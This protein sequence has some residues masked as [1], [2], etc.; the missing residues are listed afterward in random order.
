MNPSILFFAGSSR[1]ES[2]HKKL[3]RQAAT[4]ARQLGYESRFLDLKD[5][6]L[7]LYDG[8]LEAEQGVP[9]QAAALEA[10]IRRH[11]AVV[12]A[13]PEYNGAFTPLLKNSIDWVTRVDKGVLKP[14]TVGLMSA[15]PGRGGGARGLALARAWLESM[16]VEVADDPFSLPLAAQA[17]TAEGLTRD[18]AAELERF[19]ERVART[20]AAR[21]RLAA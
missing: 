9:A 4:T 19:V 3:A 6:P 17:F 12:I 8:D 21:Q 1:A 2:I 15:S 20:A 18:K 5:Y 16:R 11:D 13:S 7:P 14:K 10:V